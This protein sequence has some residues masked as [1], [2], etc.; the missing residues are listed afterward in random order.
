M[1]FFEKYGGWLID[2]LAIFT[3]LFVMAIAITT[4]VPPIYSL[5]VL[6]L[7]M[8]ISVAIPFLVYIHDESEVSESV[9]V[10]TLAS[11]VRKLLSILKSKQPDKLL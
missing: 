11:I 8:I 4:M 2:Y 10:T 5:M 7:G 1:K 6:T 3:M 9:I